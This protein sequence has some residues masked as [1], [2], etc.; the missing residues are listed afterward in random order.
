MKAISD[1]IRSGDCV[2]VKGSRGFTMEQVTAKILEDL[3]KR[4]TTNHDI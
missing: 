4:R 2:L 1:G 3:E